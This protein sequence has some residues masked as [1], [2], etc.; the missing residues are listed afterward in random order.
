[1]SSTASKK[2]DRESSGGGEDSVFL[3]RREERGDSRKMNSE[4]NS[5]DMTDMMMVIL[6]KINSAKAD[7]EKNIAERIEKAKTETVDAFRG[8][9]G[10]V[11]S[12]LLDLQV[13]NDKL[14][15]DNERL[16]KDLVNQKSEIDTCC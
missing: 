15:R 4:R 13:A 12:T 10:I 11:Q 1:M 16:K 2:R 3:E 8:E 14:T 6:E 7:T 5:E 9:I